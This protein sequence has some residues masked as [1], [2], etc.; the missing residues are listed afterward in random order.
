MHRE[1][2]ATAISNSVKLAVYI[3]DGE[4]CILCKRP[5]HWSCACAHVVR[6][7]QGGKGVEQNVVT[8][9][10]A[11]HRET[12]EGPMSKANMRDIIK[13]ITDLYPG[14]TRAQVTY[15]KGD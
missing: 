15:K 10:P 8:L 5:V 14:W 3:R 1:T 2:Q 13:Y 12:D 9:C 4:R 11:C 6:R 7:S